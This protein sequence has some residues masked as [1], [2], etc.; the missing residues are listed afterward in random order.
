MNVG[1]TLACL[2]NVAQLQAAVCNSEEHVDS[3]IQ[4]MSSQ[5]VADNKKVS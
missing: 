5:I 3:G 4:Q 2:R 1:N